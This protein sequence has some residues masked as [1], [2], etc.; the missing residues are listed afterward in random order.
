V[1]DQELDLRHRIFVAFAETG[2]PPSLA[3]EDPALIKA[4]EERH[5]IVLGDGGD[6]RMAHPFA[7]HDE[8]ATVTAGGRTWRGNCAW[9][10]FGIAAAL[11]LHDYVVESNGVRAD[12][13]VLFHVEV[14]AARWWE[15]PA[16]T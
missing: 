8:G 3:A 2:A 11:D 4:L 1:N 16:Y 10:A 9:D 15:D 7:A 5:V 12:D 6:V 14:P 13:S